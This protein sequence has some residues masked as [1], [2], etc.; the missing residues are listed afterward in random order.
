MN[1]KERELRAQI[2]S[3]LEE[4]RVDALEIRD[5]K[6]RVNILTNRIKDVSSPAVSPWPDF[7]DREQ[8]EAAI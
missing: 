1:R 8:V 5:L 3:L 6:E 7:I 4:R 2:N